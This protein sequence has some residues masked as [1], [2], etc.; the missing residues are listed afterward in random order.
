MVASEIALLLVFGLHIGGAR[1]ASA[2]A[3]ASGAIV[4]YFLNRNWAWQRRGR[5]HP[6]KELLPYWATAIAGLLLSMLATHEATALARRISDDHTVTT[7]LVGVTYLFTYGFLFVAR[8]LLFH[9]VIFTD[10]PARAADADSAEPPEDRRPAEAQ[11]TRAGA[12]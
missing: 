10:R 5:A 11:E 12:A 2:V 3:W 6:G 1:T 7:A 9:H 8:F 4:N